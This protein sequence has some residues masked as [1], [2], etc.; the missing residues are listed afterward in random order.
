LPKFKQGGPIGGRSHEAGGTIIEAE[1]GEF[2]V[3]KKSATKHRDALD[4]MN[5]SSDA[6]KRYIDQRYVRPALLDM[7]SSRKDKAMQVN[8]T[9]NAKNMEKEIKGLRK[10]LRS[11]NTTINI[12]GLD[13]RYS[14]RNN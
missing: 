2:V 13:S 1:K 4:A 14:W 7:A 8:A 5:Q 11:K 10:D 3:N 6:F 12:N 9:L